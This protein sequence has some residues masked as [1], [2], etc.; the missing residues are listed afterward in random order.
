MYYR[1]INGKI[2]L[3]VLVILV[4]VVVGLGASLFAAR[5]IRRSILSKRDLATGLAAYEKQDWSEAQK[6]LRD[7]LG[8]RP[9]DVEIWKKCA[10]AKLKTP[11]FKIENVTWTIGAYRHV[12]QMDPNDEEA[13]DEL[14]G[15]YAGIGNFRE[16]A[17]IA[18]KRLERV[19]SDRDVLLT[20]A[21]ALVRLDEMTK[22]QQALEGFFT[23]VEAPP[24]RSIEEFLTEVERV[25]GQKSDDFMRACL[26][27]SNLV[28]QED[29]NEPMRTVLEWL[30]K[31][32]QFAPDP[33]AVLAHRA[34]FYRVMAASP[35]RAAQERVLRVTKQDVDA[36]NLAEANPGELLLKVARQD[37]KAA[38]AL[39]TDDPQT[40]YFL[41]TEWLVH[42]DLEAAEAELN[43]L[44]NLSRETLDD[45]F[46]DPND[47][48]AAR[49]LFAAD[50]MTRQERTLEGALLADR[51]KVLSEPRHQ[52][53]VLP[54]AIPLYLRAAEVLQD[55]DQLEE[56]QKR[57]ADANDCLTKY[58]EALLLRKEAVQSPAERAWLSAIVARAQEKPYDVINAAQPIVA[59]NPAN[60]RLWRLLADA[61]SETG[62]TRR[63]INALKEC[64]NHRPKDEKLLRQLAL[65]YS[66]VADWENVQS[67]T[68]VVRS[69]QAAAIHTTDETAPPEVGIDLIE[70]GAELGMKLAQDANETDLE[71]LSGQLE[72]LRVKHPEKVDIRIFQAMIDKHIGNPEE[73]ERKL[74]DAISEC[75]EPLR[76]RMQ[77]VGH[78]QATERVTQAI[79]TC[80]AACEHHSEA[81]EPWLSLAALY[82]ANNDPNSARASLKRG[83][84]T[85]LMEKKRYLNIGLALLERG[86]DNERECR[87]ILQR[88]VREG[89]GEIRTRVLLLS[90]PDTPIQKDPNR[91]NDL[92]AEEL[93]AGLRRVE[94][95]SGLRWRFY[96]ASTWLRDAEGVGLEEKRNDITDVLQY[97]ISA[98]AGW[99]A[100][101]MLLGNMYERL[102]D[103]QAAV[104]TYEAALVHNPSA[105]G[106]ADRLL[107]ILIREDRLDEAQ[108]VFDRTT[109]SPRFVGAW[110]TRMVLQG[111]DVS[112][113]LDTLERSLAGSTPDAG[114]LV[115]LGR[116]TYKKTGQVDV[117]LKYL[118]NAEQIAPDDRTLAAARASIWRTEGEMDKALQV[119]DEY[120]EK[121]QGSF[122]AYWMRAVFLA[123]MAGSEEREDVAAKYLARAERDYR[124][125]T[126]FEGK[127][128]GGYVLL[129]GFYRQHKRFG[130]E[131]ER[132]D[133]AIAILEGEALQ[134]DPNDLG[135]KRML[136]AAL[137]RR[138]ADHDRQR[139][140][141][142][143]S[144]LEA[145][146][147]RDLGLTVL[148]AQLVL[149]DPNQTPESLRAIGEQ[150]EQIV[151]R[152]P[153]AAGAHLVLIGIAMRNGEHEAARDLAIRALGSNA[154]NSE[155]LLA[156]SRAELALGNSRTAQ[157]LAGLTLRKDPNNL[158]AKEIVSLARYAQAS[159]LYQTEN[160]TEAKRIYRSLL[161]DDPNNPVVLNDLAWIL[162]EHDQ[163]YEEALQLAN[164]GLSLAPDDVH[165]L[166]TRGAI[167]M[168]MSDR[169]AEAKKDFDRILEL[170]SE[171]QRRQAKTHAQLARICVK[172]NE[173]ARAK[174][175]VEKALEM[176][177]KASVLTPEER[178]EIGSILL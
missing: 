56:S 116:L 155:L 160:V 112:E 79:S 24:E 140:L 2:N 29:P 47:W 78:Y 121:A 128:A 84:A 93:I 163:N 89:E 66:R 174:D 16:L 52:I 4:V 176:D 115:Q 12:L 159:K 148:R 98:D 150:L 40:L 96:Q 172:L 137:L 71:F 153:R 144:E 70:I 21:E 86:Q 32:E 7:Y 30:N 108:R 75:E 142:L 156:R 55:K 11:P 158:A 99:V 168:N 50:L 161:N 31:A 64:L 102:G 8:R 51:I 34:R 147:P 120:V 44:D 97:C 177:Q 69:V 105:A 123:E 72:G 110:Q 20:H 9:E 104:S 162:Q 92:T 63:A 134:A 15:I 61:Y 81:V 125:L 152:E 58:R 59:T 62:Q 103:S 95:E 106:I 1:A 117:A 122:T 54:K 77:L 28:A 114:T 17:Y 82:M 101:V 133:K 167:L 42:G 119:L 124:K 178:T 38:D 165:L 88:L 145:E 111:A 60:I 49:F 68:G 149:D 83:L 45:N 37:L 23:G 25:P 3:K 146:Q 26:L 139:A 175:H 135:L 13:F 27:V 53:Q 90:S 113:A 76:A 127:E 6:H 39:G 80:E 57:V 143:L 166:D 129:S 154:G 131:K 46:L 43:A 94:G 171:D 87:D 36:S 91:P 67:M 151:R 74:V 41:G 35:D 118:D 73:A 164:R 141:E 109:V 65:E 130:T 132:F 14:A 173:L 126:T 170:A 85:V 48:E 22:A 138:N 18:E 100:P 5:Q 19:P 33:A 169:L 136:M 157:D 107:T 10:E